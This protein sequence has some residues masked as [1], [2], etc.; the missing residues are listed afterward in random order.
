MAVLSREGVSIAL[1]RAWVFVQLEIY[2][3]FQ[4]SVVSECSASATERP[5]TCDTRASSVEA[6]DGMSQA[7]IVSESTALTSLPC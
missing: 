2:K 6:S 7:E 4:Q 1:I 3:S 5:D